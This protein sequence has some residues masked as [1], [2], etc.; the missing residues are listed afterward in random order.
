MQDAEN[1]MRLTYS[2]S[3]EMQNVLYQLSLW[4]KNWGMGYAKE[5]SLCSEALGRI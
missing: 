2:L 5:F 3:L 4:N 1:K